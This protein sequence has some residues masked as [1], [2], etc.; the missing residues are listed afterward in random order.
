MDKEKLC[1]ALDETVEAI[2]DLRNPHEWDS[3]PLVTLKD[4]EWTLTELAQGLRKEIDAE[5]Y[6]AVTRPPSV[7]RGNPFQIEVGLAYGGDIIILVNFLILV[8]KHNHYLLE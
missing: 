4:L 5:F 1:D 7:Y 2:K 6:I 3:N 8:T